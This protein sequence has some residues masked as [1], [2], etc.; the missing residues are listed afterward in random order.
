MK[1]GVRLHRS[2]P[3]QIRPDE[4]SLTVYDVKHPKHSSMDIIHKFEH[5]GKDIGYEGSRY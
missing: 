2:R 1:D 4:T 5:F 3:D